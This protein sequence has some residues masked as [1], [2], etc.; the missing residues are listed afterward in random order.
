MGTSVGTEVFVKFG[1][2]AGAALSL[3]WTGLQ[4]LF[5]LVR[6]PHCRRYTWFGYEGGFEARKRKTMP[7]PDQTAPG[8]PVTPETNNSPQKHSEE[9][10][11]K[12]NMN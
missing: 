1:W 12:G 5:L 9:A 3:G 2:R 10:E 7:V 4:V 6:G 11:E 8:T